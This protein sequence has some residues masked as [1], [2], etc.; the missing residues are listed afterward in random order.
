MSSKSVKNNTV[1]TWIN[2][3]FFVKEAKSRLVITL[4]SVA[5]GVAVD[6]AMLLCARMDNDF[7]L[8]QYNL[9]T[10]RAIRF[11]ACIS[12]TVISCFLICGIYN[13]FA[14]HIVKK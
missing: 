13:L 1:S 7:F 2:K 12:A 11:V 10:D 3:W 4:L 9:S 14:R 6:L 5:I 8:N